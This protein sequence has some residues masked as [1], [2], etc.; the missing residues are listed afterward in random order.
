MMLLAISLTYKWVGGGCS[1]LSDFFTGQGLAQV[2]GQPSCPP[3][4]DHLWDD[5]GRN[6]M[7][8]SSPVCYGLT[9]PGGLLL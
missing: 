3:P 5:R 8:C 2:R 1:A 7:Q 6:Q 9:W 4:E